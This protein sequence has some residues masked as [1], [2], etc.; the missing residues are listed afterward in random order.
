MHIDNDNVFVVIRDVIRDFSDYLLYKKSHGSEYT[1]RAIKQS[2]IRH[3]L[4]VLRDL[5]I[6][7]YEP[8]ILDAPS[9]LA[10]AI[11]LHI[12]EDEIAEKI[13]TRCKDDE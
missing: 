8:D 5:E 13:L 3:E 1:R 12:Q 6:I 4:M 7:S 11:R 9:P 10:F 2:R